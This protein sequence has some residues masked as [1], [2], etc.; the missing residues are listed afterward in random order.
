MDNSYVCRKISGS[1]YYRRIYIRVRRSTSATFAKRKK[2]K[3]RIHSVRISPRN[4][5]LIC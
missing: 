3:R 5:V 1:I 2:E 4:F